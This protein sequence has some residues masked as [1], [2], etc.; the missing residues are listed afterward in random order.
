MVK[1]LLDQDVYGV[2]AKFLA[3]SDFDVVSVSQLGLSRAPDTQ[4]LS[5]AQLQGRILITRDRDY[6]NLVFVQSLGAGVL[7]L[8]ILPSTANAVHKE[9]IRVIEKYS[10]EELSNAFVVVEANGHRFRKIS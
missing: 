10:S 3:K 6:G 4:V 9:L 7:Y 1:F 5:T 8:R 2:T